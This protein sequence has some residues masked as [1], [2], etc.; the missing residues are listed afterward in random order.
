MMIATASSEAV[1]VSIRKDRGTPQDNKTDRGKALSWEKAERRDSH[2]I[3]NI[4]TVEAGGHQST[5]LV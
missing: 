5:Q 1:S 3:P 4:L 2:V